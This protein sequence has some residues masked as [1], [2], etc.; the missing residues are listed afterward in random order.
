MRRRRRL[1]LAV[2]AVSLLGV[3]GFALSLWFTSPT[4]GVT[5][6]NHRRLRVGM[7]LSDVKALFGEAALS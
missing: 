5:W 4:P 3:A 1:L 6:E 7:A 2:G